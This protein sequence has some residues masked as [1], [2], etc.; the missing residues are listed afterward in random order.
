MRFKIFIILILLTFFLPI[1]QAAYA[2]F[3]INEL[4]VPQSIKEGE[5]LNYTIVLSNNSGAGSVDVTVW[6]LPPTGTSIN[7]GT[8]SRAVPA[9]GTADFNVTIDDP[10]VVDFVNSNNPYSIYATIPT[11]PNGN[12][13]NN[14]YTKYFTVRKASK[15]IPVPDMPIVL[16]MVLAI[17]I[18][19]ILARDNKN[20]K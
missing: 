15:K 14:A 4:I 1:V 2:D 12:I 18:V 20:K 16:G 10:S 3:G 7:I 13:A 5:D 8:I 9:N 11:E 17:S 19:F 6:I